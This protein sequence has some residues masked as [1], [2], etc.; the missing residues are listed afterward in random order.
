MHRV[1]RVDVPSLVLLQLRQTRTQASAK[2]LSDGL[3]ALI[4]D[5]PSLPCLPP[6]PPQL[7]TLAA[8]HRCPPSPFG[9]S[10]PNMGLPQGLLLESCRSLVSLDCHSCTWVEVE[11]GS[12]APPDAAGEHSWILQ[13]VALPL[14]SVDAW[15]ELGRR[16]YGENFHGCEV[17][18]ARRGGAT[19]D[20]SV[21]LRYPAVQ[22]LEPAPV[23]SGVEHPR[24][25]YVHTR[26]NSNI[27]NSSK[28]ILE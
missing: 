3:S 12:R 6:M 20:Y 26:H 24:S 1:L 15:L 11:N 19:S 13:E 21:E 4:C 9:S 17:L 27:S 8:R 28:D 7:W 2:E 23:T 25:R 14:G 10:R 18:A 22:T 16:Q 5:S